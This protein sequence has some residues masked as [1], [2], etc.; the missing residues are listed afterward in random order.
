[1]RRCSL[2]LLSKRK[3]IEKRWPPRMA[4]GPEEQYAGRVADRVSETCPFCASTFLRVLFIRRSI[5]RHRPSHHAFESVDCAGETLRIG[6]RVSAA[7]RAFPNTRVTCRRDPTG[8]KTYTYRNVCRRFCLCNRRCSD[9][10]SVSGY[11]Y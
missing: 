10:D 11:P 6:L 3:G 1:M 9:T 8:V 5:S 2:G 4:G 7:G